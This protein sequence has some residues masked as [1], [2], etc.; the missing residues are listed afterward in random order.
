MQGP[1]SAPSKCN[2]NF[3]LPIPSRAHRPIGMRSA[4]TVFVFQQRQ[5]QNMANNDAEGRGAAR[6][7]DP[8]ILRVWRGA[9]ERQQAAVAE[10][11]S[12]L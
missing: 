7:A 5:S 10:M 11:G 9:E 8:L 4:G 6:A 2:L 3:F 1:M 12:H